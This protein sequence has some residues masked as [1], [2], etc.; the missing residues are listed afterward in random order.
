MSWYERFPHGRGHGAG[1]R[2][3]FSH[4]SYDYDWEYPTWRGRGRIERDPSLPP[5]LRSASS[6]SAVG[7]TRYRQGRSLRMP[8]FWQSDEEVLRAVREALIEDRWLDSSSIGIE[9]RDGVV[10]LRGK[11]ND[12][13]EARYAWDDAWEADGV[14]GVVSR[15]EVRSSE[16]MDD[17]VQM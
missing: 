9:V 1:S 6:R 14:R 8:T 11:V 16:P 5:F 17:D 2:R 13:L 10:L 12:Y 7:D 3:P 15:L 4:S